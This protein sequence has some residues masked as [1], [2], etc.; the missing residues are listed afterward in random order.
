MEGLCAP[1]GRGGRQVI[2]GDWIVGREM[3]GMLR[4]KA[5]MDP[6]ERGQI[7][8]QCSI[9]STANCETDRGLLR[10]VMTRVAFGLRSSDLVCELSTGSLV[11]ELEDRR[12]TDH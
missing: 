5:E 6:R 3:N 11:F 4:L 9:A 8:L 1:P 10:G 7:R 12:L 2:G